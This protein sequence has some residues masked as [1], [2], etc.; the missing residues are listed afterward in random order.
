MVDLKETKHEPKKQFWEQVSEARAGML[1]VPHLDDVMQPM[2]AR[3]EPAAN[4]LWFFASKSSDLCQKIAAGNTEAHFALVGK[5]HDYHATATGTIRE[6]KDPAKVE[7][8][9]DPIAAAW[10]HGGKEDP[11]M[12]L[13]EMTCEKASIWGSSDS[14]LRF[15]WQI[16]K[17]NIDKDQ[18]PDVGARVDVKF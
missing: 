4:K 8:F 1:G 7:E 5:K 17:A 16:A 2:S 6:N 11:D 12:T 10:F 13:L 9:W 14:S 18:V 3:E 15:G